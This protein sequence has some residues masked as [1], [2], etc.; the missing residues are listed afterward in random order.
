MTYAVLAL[1]LVVV[2]GVDPLQCVRALCQVERYRLEVELLVEHLVLGVAVGQHA[3]AVDEEREAV[4]GAVVGLAQLGVHTV[5]ELDVVGTFLAGKVLGDGED[6]L[7]LA[8]A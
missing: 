8:V 2:L 7:D 5:L 6:R 1:V 4:A 3:L